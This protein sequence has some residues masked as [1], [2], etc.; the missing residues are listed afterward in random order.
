MFRPA[1]ETADTGPEVLFV[2]NSR[3]VYRSSVRTAI[4]AGAPVTIHGAGWEPFVAPEVVA[5]SYVANAELGALYA[6][7]GVVLNDHWEDM[8]RDGFV[9]NRLFD[10]A[11]TGARIVSDEVEGIAELFGG[12]V[13]P[14]HDESDLRRLVAE[15]DTAFPDVEQRRRIAADVALAH[16]F[17]ARAATL[18]D[19]A[20]RLVADRRRDETRA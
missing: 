11:A 1:P 16:S 4:A 3:G 5:S 8:R 12:L 13:V 18:V 9:S 17:D 20:A 15:R 6:S 14:F 19:A 10:A 2:G 7:A